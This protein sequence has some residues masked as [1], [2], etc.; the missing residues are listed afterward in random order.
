MV[1]DK[2]GAGGGA[3]LK[4]KSKSK[5]NSVLCQSL[6]RLNGGVMKKVL[7]GRRKTVVEQNE[8]K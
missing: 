6:N 2:G 7:G 1:K 5:V 4:N 3:I 8:S